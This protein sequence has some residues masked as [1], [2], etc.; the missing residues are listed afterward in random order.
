MKTKT[1]TTFTYLSAVY[2]E[3]CNEAI[4]PGEGVIIEGNIYLVPADSSQRPGIIGNNI[5][6][7]GKDLLINEVAY[8]GTCFIELIQESMQNG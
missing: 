3:L 2:C 7:T 1:V 5:I 8:H 4:Q 6:T